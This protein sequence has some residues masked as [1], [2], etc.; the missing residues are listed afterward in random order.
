MPWI[1]SVCDNKDFVTLN[2]TTTPLSSES[3]PQAQ[4]VPSLS[5]NRSICGKT[6][7]LAD[8]VE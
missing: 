7:I 5:G 1:I 8:P 6:H 4:W 3:C 2:Q